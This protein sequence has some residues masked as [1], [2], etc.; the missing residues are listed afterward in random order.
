MHEDRRSECAKWWLN[1]KLCETWVIE[2][3]IEM[4]AAGVLHFLLSRYEFEDLK[5]IKDPRK[6]SFT[7]SNEHNFR[8]P[9][10]NDCSWFEW[11]R[12]IDTLES[13]FQ[14]DSFLN[15]EISSGLYIYIQPRYSLDTALAR[16]L[17]DHHIYYICIVQVSTYH[18]R[19]SVDNCESFLSKYTS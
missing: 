1:H 10:F 7:A 5:I 18:Y 2:S 3:E 13:Y 14:P 9:S 16:A 15:R 4:Q 11:I 17:Y 19:A 8:L 12:K 6:S